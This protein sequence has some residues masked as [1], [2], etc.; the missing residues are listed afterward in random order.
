MK[1]IKRG[2]VYLA[3]LDPIVGSEQGG[4]R[5]VIVIQNNVGNTY[6]PTII[7]AALTSRSKKDLPT[8]VKIRFEGMPGEST[9]MLEQIR[10]IDRSRLLNFVGTIEP[11][12]MIE[13]EKAIEISFGLSYSFD[14]N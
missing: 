11:S 14:D 8:H 3:N 6:S 1:E 10:T 5:P 12:K 7:V 9:I 13:V 4:I 2:Q